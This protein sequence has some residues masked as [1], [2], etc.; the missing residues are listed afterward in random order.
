MSETLEFQR[1]APIGD[2][3]PQ[4]LPVSDVESATRYYTD[5]LGFTV[6]R[7]EGAPPQA[8]VLRRDDVELRLAVTGADP[9][10]ASC[11]IGVS[12][13]DALHREYQAAG[14]KVSENVEPMEYGGKSYRVIWVKDIDGICYCIGKQ[15]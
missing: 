4:N 12:D 9:E 2:T 7:Y 13:I 10:Q 1:I 11:Y 5:T 6:D 14:A 8:V 3:D 15:G